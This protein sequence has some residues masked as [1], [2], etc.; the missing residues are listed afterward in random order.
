MVSRIEAERLA[1]S[2]NGTTLSVDG[3]FTVSGLAPGTYRLAATVLDN[4]GSGRASWYG[5][6][7]VPVD[8][9]DVEGVTV[10]LRAGSVLRG[11]VVT[12]D[13][14]ALPI[15]TTDVV[16]AARTLD[17]VLPPIAP[18]ARVGSN[19]A[20][21]VRGAFGRLFIRLSSQA[22]PAAR[23][24]VVKS[25]TVGGQDVT[26]TPVDFDAGDVEAE[27]VVTSR[28]SEVGGTVTWSRVAD[29]PRPTVFVFSADPEA[30]IPPTLRVRQVSVDE[31]GRFRTFGLPPGDG[32]VVVAVEDTSIREQWTPDLLEAL[33]HE[34]TSLRIDPG[35]VHELSLRAVRRPSVE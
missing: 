21:E 4:S 25:V 27:I 23:R 3:S 12:D 22:S 20:F 30:W 24:W 17:N 9:A 33:R 19:G 31:D 5:S 18:M 15:G 29:G 14:S 34:A 28:V 26:E 10:S 11:R 6:V 8:G 7:D 13:G 32:Y 1:S 35:G 2:A 16:L